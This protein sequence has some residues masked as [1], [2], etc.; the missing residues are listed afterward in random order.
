[1]NVRRR[2]CDPK[3]PYVCSSARAAFERRR[4]HLQLRRACLRSW[5]RAALERRSESTHQFRLNLKVLSSAARCT[6]ARWAGWRGAQVRKLAWLRDGFLGPR[7]ARCMG[8]CGT[9]AP[10]AAK[11]Y[12]VAGQLKREG[13]G[14]TQGPQPSGAGR[15]REPQVP[16]REQPRARRVDIVAVKACS[17]VFYHHFLSLSFT[18]LNKQEKHVYHMALR[19]SDLSPF[20]H[21]V[22][23]EGFV[24]SS[25]NSLFNQYVHEVNVA[26][27]GLL[28]IR[29]EVEESLSLT[30]ILCS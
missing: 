19:S 11:S 29:A 22:G 4:V 26:A 8:E 1:M 25:F 13:S 7:A 28:F 10:K 9:C 30:N 27:Q 6:L 20:W 23:L 21:A 18:K 2:S 15:V 24:C 5:A 3:G 16:A 14:G 17:Q 12:S